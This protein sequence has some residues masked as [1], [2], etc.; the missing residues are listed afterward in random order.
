MTQRDNSAFMGGLLVA[1]LL[2]AL[3][4]LAAAYGTGY[5]DH[6]YTNALSATG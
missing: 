1:V 2:P 5:L 4:I 6:L 3:L